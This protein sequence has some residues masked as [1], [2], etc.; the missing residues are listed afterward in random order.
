MSEKYS[1]EKYDADEVGFYSRDFFARTG[2]KA[3]PFEFSDEQVVIDQPEDA[4]DRAQHRQIA[5]EFNGEAQH[6]HTTDLE[7]RGNNHLFQHPLLP[8]EV[9]E[10]PHIEWH[11]L[12]E[13][14]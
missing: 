9:V 10:L 12:P 4:I 11:D 6:P 3:R 13:D 7:P 8:G 14:H 5:H 2:L 1:P